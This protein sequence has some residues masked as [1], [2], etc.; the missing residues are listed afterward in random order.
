VHNELSGDVH[1]L[2]LQARDVHLH[3]P[4]TTALAGL[5][6]VDTG[7]TGRTADLTLVGEALCSPRPVVV[8]TVMGLAGV[9]KTT[10]AI[11][12]A[13]DAVE[14]GQFPGG[15]LFVD[16]Q[17][18][19]AQMRQVEP[20][21]ALSIF[22]Q[23]LGIPAERVPAEQAA[24]EVLYRTKL[25]ERAAPM[26]I[27]LDNASS[28]GQI[29]PLLPPDGTHRVL[30]TSRHTLGELQGSRRIPLD[31]LSEVDSVAMLDNVLLAADPA[32][33]RIGADIEAAQEIVRFC[34]RLPLA[35][36]IIAAVL[37]EDPE[38]PL[39]GVAVSLREA[40]TRLSELS[41]HDN[42][43]VR[44][45]FDL[46]YARLDVAEARLFRL[47]SLNPGRQASTE[48]AAAVTDL[49]PRQTR[50]LLDGLRRAHMIEHGEPHGW[51][52]FHD[53]L[54]LY[55]EDR[56]A[57]DEPENSRHIATRRLIDYYINATEVAGRQRPSIETRSQAHTWLETERANLV[58]AIGLAHQ[59]GQYDRV[60]R[61]AFAMGTFLFYRRRHG[62][63]GLACFELALDAAVRLGDRLGEV[64][65]LC[66]LGRIHREMDHYAAAGERF[67]AAVVLSR[68]LGDYRGQAQ[69]LHNLGSLAR[70]RDD[71]RSAWKL[72]RKALAV[73]CTAGD[74]FGE[75]Q[76]HFSMG[77]LAR[78]RE[79]SGLAAA[80]YRT[81]I[82]ICQ[83]IGSHELEGR[84][85]ERLGLMA[86]DRGDLATARDH[87]ETAFAVLTAAG[88]RHRAE[89]VLP[90]LRKV[91]RKL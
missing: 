30:V 14:A 21:A 6:P 85:H 52:R 1:G 72:Y 62:E 58:G 10:L 73:Y 45:A 38:Q 25:T 74:R 84:A 41:Y 40:T 12:A 67:E 75:A 77:V 42:L 59:H 80:H 22:L 8:S 48:A 53:L 35:L 57:T 90:W 31:V 2:V 47:L 28:A 7:F 15:V 16:L 5:P 83:Q 43:A 56:A 89:S 44:A 68:M 46:S 55:A 24:R 32:D 49:P 76:I 65:A 78:G 34:G 37:S 54:R 86:Q 63:D 11:K 13:H 36:S 81:T 39:A 27:V 71:F 69:A 20:Q 3:A 91:Q 70:R 87:L 9:G 33:L 23:A 66:G 60:L 88:E 19:S 82:E 18:Y 51:F 79:E 61:L 17:G 50:K 26:L 64:K 29:R 4:P